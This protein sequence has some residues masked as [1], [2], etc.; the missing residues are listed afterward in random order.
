MVELAY[1]GYI[2]GF[3]VGSKTFA[4]Y[5]KTREEMMKICDMIDI[6]TDQIFVIVKGVKPAYLG[7]LEARV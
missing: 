2:K 7:G 6:D 1:S 3:L 4:A 5:G